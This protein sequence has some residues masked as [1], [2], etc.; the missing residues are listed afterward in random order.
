MKRSYIYNQGS[1]PREE[2]GL[3]KGTRCFGVLNGVSAPFA[4]VYPQQLYDGRSGGEVVARMVERELT[5]LG[6]L[7][8]DSLVGDVMYVNNRVNEF[9]GPEMTSG[10]RHGGTF[11]FGKILGEALRVVQ[12][13]ECLAIVEMRDGGVIVSPNQLRAH[14]TELN[15]VINGAHDE[16][17]REMFGVTFEQ[18]PASE[19]GK[20]RGEAWNRAVPPLRQ[21]RLEDWNQSTS[22]RCVGV[23]CGQPELTYM[24][25]TES[26]L[27]ENIATAL[28]MTNGLL[29]WSVM[30]GREKIDSDM[31][32]ARAVLAT[33]KEGGL[34]GL[35]LTARNKEARY[36]PSHYTNN[37]E[38]TGYAIDF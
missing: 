11:A 14:D 28:F 13:G 8:D 31:E 35:L 37:T 4:P 5:R 6:D 24:L 22:R 15:A 36:G 1:A 23:L 30:T 32:T 10:Q 18:V 26:F 21:A 34:P 25:W 27:V 7:G 17:A 38:A 20:V 29:A 3:V 2:D 12:A 9:N 33:Y 16:V 19:K